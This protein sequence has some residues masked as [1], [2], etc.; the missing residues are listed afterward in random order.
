MPSIVPWAVVGQTRVADAFFGEEPRSAVAERVVDEG[1]GEPET[2]RILSSVFEIP[3]AASPRVERF[4]FSDALC[5][6]TRATLAA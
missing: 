2:E 5:E 1:V 4:P 6:R 3:L